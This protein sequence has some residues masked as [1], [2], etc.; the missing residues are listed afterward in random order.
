[1]TCIPLSEASF[2]TPRR[3]R[4]AD[5]RATSWWTTRAARP[6][7]A[8]PMTPRARR[9]ASECDECLIVQQQPRRSIERL[10]CRLPPSE[11]GLHPLTRCRIE[12]L[13]ALDLPKTGGLKLL[14]MGGRI[15]DPIVG[16]L[17]FLFKVSFAYQLRES[18]VY[19]R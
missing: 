16:Q 10:R 15:F 12:I 11:Q 17:E 3:G 4:L 14:A 5:K 18:L 7:R 6:R 9:S 13:D 8:L 2:A 1:M 19:A